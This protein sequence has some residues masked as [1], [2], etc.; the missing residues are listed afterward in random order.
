MR[1][2]S[3][4]ACVLACV[5][6]RVIFVPKY[7]IRNEHHVVLVQGSRTEPSGATW[8][9]VESNTKCSYNNSVISAVDVVC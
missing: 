5:Y 9:T 1:A 8:R 2:C 6:A 7:I 3:L 4:R